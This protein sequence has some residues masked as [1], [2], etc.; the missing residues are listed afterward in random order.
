MNRHSVTAQATYS[1][2][3]S[4]LRMLEVNEFRYGGSFITKEVRGKKYWYHA[5]KVGGQLRHK[6]IGPDTNDIKQ[7]IEVGKETIEDVRETRKRTREMVKILTNT[8]YNRPDPVTSRLLARLASA[9]AFRLRAVL[10]GTHA[11]RCYDGLLGVKLPET[12]AVTA[13]VDVAQFKTISIAVDDQIEKP[14]DDLLEEI[15]SRFDFVP[16]LDPKDGHAEWRIKGGDL[17]FELLCP[18]VGPDDDSLQDLP[19]L[20][21]RGK[22]LRFLDYLIYETEDAA[23]LY[24]T[25]VL[26]KVPVPSRYACHKL[27]V[28][29]RRI[30]ARLG[31]ASKAR[32]D[33]AQAEALF[34]VLLKDRRTEL[35]YA[36]RELLDRGPKW[37]LY[38]QNALEGIDPSIAKEI[39]SFA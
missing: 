10:V 37:R 26:I 36:W 22:P 34:E 32:K 29:Q 24:E 27:I 17:T 35:Q 31:D 2:L 23:I 20:G 4:Q 8:G 33:L 13:D 14:I 15:D 16:R 30:E 19:A 18:L 21:G 12:T 3:V 7:Q 28:S 9:G 5:E 25:G 1:E 11:Y 39:R 6:Y 38:A